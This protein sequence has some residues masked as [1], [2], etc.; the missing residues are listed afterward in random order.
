[1]RFR[2][3]PLHGRQ[4]SDFF[5]SEGGQVA[6]DGKEHA[7]HRFAELQRGAHHRD[8]SYRFDLGID[9][10]NKPLVAQVIGGVVRP[11]LAG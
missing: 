8:H 9:D 3:P 2:S 6:V 7:D 11:T 1:M 10:V 5:I 4:E